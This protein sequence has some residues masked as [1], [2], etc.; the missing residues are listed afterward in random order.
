MSIFMIF[1][2]NIYRHEIILLKLFI[3]LHIDPLSFILNIHKEIIIKTKCKM[4]N[5]R[6]NLHNYFGNYVFL[7]IFALR[8]VHEF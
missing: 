7:Y 2:L 6:V 1:F 5:V 3:F 4:N 8:D